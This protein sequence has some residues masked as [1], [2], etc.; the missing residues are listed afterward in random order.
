M[1]LAKGKET[2]KERKRILSGWNLK[3]LQVEVVKFKNEE[4]TEESAI[5]RRSL[6]E[7]KENEK[8]QKRKERK[9]QN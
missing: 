7:E 6:C 8:K 9:P 3:K 5:K 1:E 2:E 4:E